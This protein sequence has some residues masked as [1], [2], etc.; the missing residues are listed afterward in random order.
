MD[1]E[2]IDLGKDE[3]IEN[4]EYGYSEEEKT[5]LY[6]LKCIK[7]LCENSSVRSSY[8]GKLSDFIEYYKT[9]TLLQSAI[10]VNLY[11]QDPS[12]REKFSK[13]CKEKNLFLLHLFNKDASSRHST[14]YYDILISWD[15]VCKLSEGLVSIPCRL[16][17]YKDSGTLVFSSIRKA[18]ECCAN[19]FD[20]CVKD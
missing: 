7:L 18:I 9:C 1:R 19:H 13:I 20:Y 4:K 15:D 14:W 10:I 5:R 6:A 17:R 16:L 2:I 11:R 12:E 8:F 3:F